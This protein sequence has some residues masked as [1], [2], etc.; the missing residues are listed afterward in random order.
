MQKQKAELAEAGL[1]EDGQPPKEINH[2]GAASASGNVLDGSE[3]A[4]LLQTRFEQIRDVARPHALERPRTGSSLCTATCTDK[5]NKR[6]Q[7][8]SP[9]K[10]EAKDSTDEV[11]D[12]DDESKKTQ[13]R[14]LQ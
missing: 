5:G 4:A 6:G 1:G 9:A 14:R 10:Y 8:A 13:R 7:P 3:K 11:L 12:S 2:R